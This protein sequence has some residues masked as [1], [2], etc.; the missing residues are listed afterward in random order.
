MQNYAT[1]RRASRARLPAV[2]AFAYHTAIRSKTVHI[3]ATIE[4][5][6]DSTKI[7]DHGAQGIFEREGSGE[8]G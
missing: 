5:I 4:R 8:R 2:I 3:T 1:F 7:F 6:T